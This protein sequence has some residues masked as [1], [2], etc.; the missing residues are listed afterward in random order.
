MPR[1][2]PGSSRQGRPAQH[3]AQRFAQRPALALF[4]N[5]SLH[6]ATGFLAVGVHYAILYGLLRVGIDPVAGS[7]VGFGGG[8]LTRFMLSYRHVFTPSHSLAIAGQRFLVALGIQFVANGAL[9]ASLLAAGLSVW[10]AQ[11]ATTIALTFAN[12]AIYRLW[13]FR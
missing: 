6:V 9:L 2:E 10:P 13:V 12:Y 5:F 3:P 7:A 4:A 1:P 11:I 8:A